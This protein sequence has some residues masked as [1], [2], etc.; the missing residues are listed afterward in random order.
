M[1][2]GNG[3]KFYL[4]GNSKAAGNSDFFHAEYEPRNQYWVMFQVLFI[5]FVT[6]SEYQDNM[7]VNTTRD[8]IIYLFC[9]SLNISVLMGQH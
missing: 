4:L 8:K 5:T 9:I 6:K 3:Q 2:Q 7:Q 1:Y